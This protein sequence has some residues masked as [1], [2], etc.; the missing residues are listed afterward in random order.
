MKRLADSL[1]L[2]AAPV[3]AAMAALAA[4]HGDPAMRMLCGGDAWRVDG[5]ACMYAL[6]SAFHA[7]P[8][9]RRL[10]GRQDQTR[11][12]MPRFAPCRRIRGI[13]GKGEFLVRPKEMN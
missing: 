8:W 13:P 6:M 3:F 4:W 7:A 9:L 5:M 12:A 11:R 10:A 1:C 2:A